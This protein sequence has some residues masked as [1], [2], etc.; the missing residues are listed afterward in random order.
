MKVESAPA[1]WLEPALDL[2]ALVC[3]VVIHDQVDFLIGGKV[4]LQVVEKTD[5]FPAAVAVLAG[6]DHLAVE[7]IEGGKQRRCA[8]TLVIVGL[9]LGQPRS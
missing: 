9:P 6:P 5:E 8:V 2:G 3:A 7:N 4:S 1:F